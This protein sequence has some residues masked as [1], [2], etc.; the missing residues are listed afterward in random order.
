MEQLETQGRQKNLVNPY[1]E[2]V[3]EKLKGIF[4]KNYIPV[5]FKPTNTLRQRLVHLKDRRP[6]HNISNIVYMRSNAKS[7]TLG[8]PNS[9]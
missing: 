9:H 8:K 7:S 5:H 6:K 1:M 4:G 2:G 3:P